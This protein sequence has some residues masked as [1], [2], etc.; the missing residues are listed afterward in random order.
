MSDS[1]RECAHLSTV[2]NSRSSS[3]FFPS[4]CSP[5]THAT[6]QAHPSREARRFEV[7]RRG[8]NDTFRNKGESVLP[9]RRDIYGYNGTRSTSPPIP[10]TPTSSSI[11]VRGTLFV[12]KYLLLPITR[13][14]VYCLFPRGSTH[15][16]TY[17]P[18]GSLGRER[19]RQL[20][21][22]NCDF[23]KSAKIFSPF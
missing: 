9:A 1:G 8:K 3:R 10:S 11:P 4:P 22:S 12:Q 2:H 6:Q 13:E 14:T 19:V 23:S 17:R 7:G 20:G 21:T 18:P 15:S 5:P 16:S